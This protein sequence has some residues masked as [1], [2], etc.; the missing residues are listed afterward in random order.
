MTPFRDAAGV[1]RLRG[2]TDRP[3][4][5]SQPRPKCPQNPPGY[6][7]EIASTPPRDPL[8]M[9]NTRLGLRTIDGLQTSVHLSSVYLQICSKNKK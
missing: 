5:P 9:E 8:R 7:A 6:R 4:R 1:Y 2:V 3:R